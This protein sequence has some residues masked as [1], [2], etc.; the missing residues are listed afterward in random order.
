MIHL[1]HE[2]QRQGFSITLS[3]SNRLVVTPKEELTPKLAEELKANE[4]KI[5]S[6]LRP[7]KLDKHPTE[8]RQPEDAVSQRKTRYRGGKRQTNII[9]LDASQ[10]PTYL[11]SRQGRRWCE[12]YQLPRYVYLDVCKR[13]LEE[14]DPKCMGCKRLSKEDVEMWMD[15]Y[16]NKAIAR[17]NARY[18]PC[19]AINWDKPGAREQ[20]DR[21]EKAITHSFLQGDLDGCI[22]AVNQWEA[23]FRELKVSSRGVK[24]TS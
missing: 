16:L 6:I 5:I 2:L 12:G 10:E 1:L 9:G 3:G 24:G 19:G 22:E 21:L 23:L 18:S 13:H 4:S 14:A 17:L 8:P 20:I 11:A 7:S 15:A